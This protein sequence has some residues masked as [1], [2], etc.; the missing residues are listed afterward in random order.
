[1]AALTSL[2]KFQ[3][4]YPDFA[5]S[6]VCE[7]GKWGRLNITWKKITNN[8]PQTYEKRF[9]SPVVNLESGE[10]F[11]PDSRK[12]IKIKFGY[13]LVLTPIYIVAKTILH[14][15]LPLS[16]PIT[17]K[18]TLMKN[19]ELKAFELT[20][21]CFKESFK[22]LADIVRTPLYGVALLIVDLAALTLIP[23]D[24]TLIYDLRS[25]SGKL[26]KS[27][28]WGRKKTFF[29]CFQAA[30]CLDTFSKNA[31]PEAAYYNDTLY[32][33]NLTLA[34]QKMIHYGRAFISTMSEGKAMIEDRKKDSLRDFVKYNLF[35]P[36]LI[37]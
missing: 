11:F 23:F 21:L 28:E 2:Q 25:L 13:H 32:P 14:V 1:M 10:Y 29:P 12:L 3:Q 31:S 6:V 35:K 33:K 8:N 27:L 18:Q 20:T 36:L 16:L 15:L 5:S 24:T 4:K 26:E 9:H 22:S 19:K 34:H 7:G 37:D 30:G 17:I